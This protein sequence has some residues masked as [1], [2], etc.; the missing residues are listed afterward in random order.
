MIEFI[1]LIL[2][3]CIICGFSYWRSRIVETRLE[4]KMDLISKSLHELASELRH[5]RINKK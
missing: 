1:N 4:N 5:E 3:L 2:I